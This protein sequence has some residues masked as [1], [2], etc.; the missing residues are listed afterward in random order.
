MRIRAKKNKEI[1]QFAATQTVVLSGVSLAVY[2]TAFQTH[3]CNILMAIFPNVP[4]LVL[5]YNLASHFCKARILLLNARQ[6][7]CICKTRLRLQ[8]KQSDF[9]AH[10]VKIVSWFLWSPVQDLDLDST[11]QLSSSQVSPRFSSQIAMFLLG[12]LNFLLPPPCFR[13]QLHGDSGC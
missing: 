12:R 1:L 11:L 13:R 10:T 6:E 2:A 9:L 3:F 4:F 5:T 7:L 8:M